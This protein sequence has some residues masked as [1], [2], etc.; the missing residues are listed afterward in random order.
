MVG[1]DVIGRDTFQDIL[2]A[3]RRA[4][5]PLMYMQ[6][7][8]YGTE[9]LPEG[10]ISQIWEAEDEEILQKIRSLLHNYVD[11]FPAELPKELPP[12]RGLGDEHHIETDID[13]VPPKKAA[14]R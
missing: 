8:V 14:Y 6:E 3:V 11:I 10:V 9:G 1:E 4:G 7:L 12:N 13:A 2:P 5:T